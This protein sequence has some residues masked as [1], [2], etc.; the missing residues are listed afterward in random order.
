MNSKQTEIRVLGQRSIA[1]SFLSRSSNPSKNG[2][3]D[4]NDKATKRVSCVSFS[5]FLDQKLHKTSVLPTT[6]QGCHFFTKP[7]LIFGLD[8]QIEIKKEGE[9]EKNKALDKVLSEQFKQTNAEKRDAPDELETPIEDSVKESQK[10]RNP[11]AGSDDRL[12]TQRP[13]IILGDDSKYKR[14]GREKGRKE[15]LISNKKP[16]P[17]YNHYANGS[18]WWDSG[19]EGID[20]EEVGFGE[21]WE[22][23]GCTTFGGI[24]WH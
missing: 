20:D 8:G 22:G 4:V 13:F 5:E 17:H 6:V 7:S 18:G 11:F 12:P 3:E 14:K 9:E 10:R 21:A 1:S 19:M 15:S 24:E 23:V 16:R 2:K